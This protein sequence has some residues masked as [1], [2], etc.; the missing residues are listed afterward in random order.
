MEELLR[1]KTRTNGLNTD[2]LEGRNCSIRTTP[3]LPDNH[4][5]T[6]SIGMDTI[7]RFGPIG[8]FRFGDFNNTLFENEQVTELIYK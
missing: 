4:R 1:I 5:V 8:N 7:I 6:V 3:L 2:R